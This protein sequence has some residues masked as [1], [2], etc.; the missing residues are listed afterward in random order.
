VTR[1]VTQQA[2][3]RQ[4]QRVNQRRHQ[5]LTLLLLLLSMLRQRQMTLRPQ[6]H[7]HLPDPH[8]VIQRAGILPLAQ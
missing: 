2:R 6:V 8:R 7:H 5:G 1:Q 4:R 3:N